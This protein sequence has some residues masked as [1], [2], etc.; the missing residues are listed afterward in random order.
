M[1]TCPNCGEPSEDLFDTCWNC[2]GRGEEVRPA[3]PIIGSSSAEP[4][5]TEESTLC[6]AKCKSPKIIPAA[7]L[8]DRSESAS[9]D[10]SAFV[11]QNPE[12]FVFRGKVESSLRARICGECGYTEIWA[13]APDVLYEAYRAGQH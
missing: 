4:T 6:C 5:T 8:L 7:R 2:A 13:V 10:L 9:K 3:P 11:E 1:W 12:A